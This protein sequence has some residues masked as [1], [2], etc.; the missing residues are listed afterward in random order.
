MSIFASKTSKMREVS[1]I[2]LHF[3]QQATSAIKEIYFN[4]F[5][6][7]ERRSWDSINHLLSQNNS[8]YNIDII[9]CDG[10][11]AGFISWWQ[12]LDF[13]YIEHFAIKQSMR[14]MRIGTKAISQFTETKN[15]PIVLEVELP[16]SGEMAQRRIAFYA[17]NGFTAH[18]H[19]EYIQPSYGAGLPPVPL[20]LMT[21]NTPSS[22]DLNN[23]S[24]QLHSVVYGV[25]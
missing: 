3:H 21:A 10:E 17:Q 4:S 2:K 25:K 13:C 20:M 8:P 19:F 14:G 12:F 23:I 7:E 15:M 16:N 6:P 9:L 18:P 24:Q 11:V 22:I 5:P 1:L